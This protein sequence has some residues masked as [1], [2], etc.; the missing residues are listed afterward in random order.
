D[1]KE[2]LVDF[3]KGLAVVRARD[4]RP[5]VVVGGRG[6]FLSLFGVDTESGTGSLIKLLD[7]YL[8]RPGLGQV[9]TFTYES[10]ESPAVGTGR[11]ESPQL[12]PAMNAPYA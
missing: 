12:E 2:D 11:D 9:A 4:G 5:H 8:P 1:L 7:V 6:G 3:P 10:S